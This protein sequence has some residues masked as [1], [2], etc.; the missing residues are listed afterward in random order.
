MPADAYG[1]VCGGVE[2]VGYHG[3][4]ELN[5]CP[6][7]GGAPPPEK[8]RR[9][10]ADGLPGA[11]RERFNAGPCFVKLL[12]AH[13][14]AGAIIGR[15]G[16]ALEHL[17]RNTGSC[18]KIAPANCYYPGSANERALVIAGDD[19]AVIR[20]VSEG[21]IGRLEEDSNA[22]GSGGVVSLRFL[23]PKAVCGSII[24]RGGQE[25]RQVCQQTTAHVNI[26]QAV[27]Q[28]EERV[29]QIQGTRSPVEQASAWLLLRL[30]APENIDAV[31]QHLSV[32]YSDAAASS[33]GAASAVVQ[34]LPVAS[35]APPVYQA[36]PAPAAHAAHH[37]SP[38]AA[39]AAAAAAAAHAAAAAPAGG[40]DPI[41]A[42]VS[43]YAQAQAGGA[44]ASAAPAPHHARGGG[45]APT[46][47]RGT[48]AGAPLPPVAQPAT[49]S[50]VTPYWSVAVAHPDVLDVNC[51][52]N[53][54]VTSLQ[55]GS[56]MGK[57]GRQIKEITQ[58]TRSRIQ[59]S[60]REPGA[61]IDAPRTVEVTGRAEDVQAA[62]LLLLK[63]MKTADEEGRLRDAAAGG[64]S[65]YYPSEAP[66]PFGVGMPVYPV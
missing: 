1:G 23:A 42:L 13:E 8:R 12:V 29:V 63:C 7:V 57:Q 9:V 52:I 60:P 38:S 39:H 65:L 54:Q 31:R 35:H 18:L 32:D 14:L 15:A 47:S 45:A 26:L 59:L 10:Q 48:P 58:F 21:I 28:L 44:Q 37:A 33:Y 64:G 2:G 11:K 41:A 34:H 22:T 46:P 5:G 55:A 50:Q 24:G 61:P 30:N 16:E 25:V 49:Q 36:A 66:S 43:A 19:K 40:R 62:H 3:G 17:E 6:P 20:A 51:Q 56:I 53:F 27:G 4:P